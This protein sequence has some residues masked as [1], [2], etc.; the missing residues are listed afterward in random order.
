[1]PEQPTAEPAVEPLLDHQVLDLVLGTVEE[2]LLAL[3]RLQAR[4]ERAWSAAALVLLKYY[5]L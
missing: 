2:P 1:L 4:V 5:S 3:P